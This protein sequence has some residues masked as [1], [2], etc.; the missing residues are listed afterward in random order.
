MDWH[1]RYKAYVKNCEAWGI[2]PMSFEAWRDEDG[3]YDE[4]AQNV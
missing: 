2:E 3:D 4:E 1:V